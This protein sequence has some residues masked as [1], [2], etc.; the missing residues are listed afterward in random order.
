MF[1]WDET[2]KKMLEMGETAKGIFSSAADRTQRGARVA[3]LKVKIVMEENKINRAYGELGKRVYEL[4]EKKED[5]IAGSSQV[6]EIA[7]AIKSSRQ[8]IA[9][10]NA[11]I[12]SFK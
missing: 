5:N 2:K 11:E 12:K 8:T 1:D 10:I 9:D 6:K 4:I 7:K 3:S